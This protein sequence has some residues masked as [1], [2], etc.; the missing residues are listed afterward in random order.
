VINDIHGTTKREALAT[1]SQF[2]M[3]MALIS[4]STPYD[5]PLTAIHDLA[6]LWVLKY[7]V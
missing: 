7:W 6:G 2:S 3:A 1:G 5:K 4:T